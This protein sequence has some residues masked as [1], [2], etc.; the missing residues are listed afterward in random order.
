MTTSNYIPHW[1]ERA[2]EDN[3][4][5]IL[6]TQDKQLDLFIQLIKDYKDAHF[7][8]TA[9]GSVRIGYGLR[10]PIQTTGLTIFYITKSTL[11]KH[12]IITQKD[13]DQYFL[14]IDNGPTAIVMEPTWITRLESYNEIRVED[15]FIPI[16]VRENEVHVGNV[17]M[18]EDQFTG[19]IDIKD[20]FKLQDGR[21]V[22]FGEPIRDFIVPGQ[23]YY[24]LTENLSN[25]RVVTHLNVKWNVKDNNIDIYRVDRTVFIGNISMSEREF[26]E[27]IETGRKIDLEDGRFINIWQVEDGGYQVKLNLDDSMIVDYSED[28]W[29][30]LFENNG[31]TEMYIKINPDF[32]ARTSEKVF[33]EEFKVFSVESE[34]NLQ[35]SLETY[36]QTRL[37]GE[38]DNAFRRRGSMWAVLGWGTRVALREKVLE[39]YGEYPE[40][41]Y[42][43][44]EDKLDRFLIGYSFIGYDGD[45]DYTSG[46]VSDKTVR[47]WR[48]HVKFKDGTTSPFEEKEMIDKLGELY[49]VIPHGIKLVIETETVSPFPPF[50]PDNDIPLHP[51]FEKEDIPQVWTSG[52]VNDKVV[53]K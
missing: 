47:A 41:I 5:A 15:E 27:H 39:V 33:V 34:D 24:Q 48:I 40:E 38:S 19:H 29:A 45:H 14:S 20:P 35:L 7:P 4:T 32:Y 51:Q 18:P 25:N 13:D 3:N 42:I 53:S 11:G 43:I 50:E 16:H 26:K 44:P 1:Y 17:D 31:I 2:K 9:T 10:Y 23:P 8:N 12:K 28:Q 46:F 6:S 49:T 37:Q 30:D 21:V 36:G 22:I 52:I